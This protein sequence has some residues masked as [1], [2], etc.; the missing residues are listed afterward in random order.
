MAQQTDITTE[1]F[2]DAGLSPEQSKVQKLRMEG[3]T[4]N[5]IAR[6]LQKEPGTV[7]SH[8]NRIDEKINNNDARLLPEVSKIETTARVGEQERPSI[9][10]WFDN[11]TALRYT[12]NTETEN[13][14]E[15]TYHNG[16]VH[17]SYPISGDREQLHEYTLETLA[18]YINIYRDDFESLR[19]DWPHVFELLTGIEA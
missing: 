3:L 12:W 15:E 7:K 11:D 9:I 2:T 4:H 18:E 10:I 6:Q 17:D 16:V 5:E 8:I 13:I 1:T 19:N 14:E